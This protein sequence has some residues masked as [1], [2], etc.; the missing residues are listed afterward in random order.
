MTPFQQLILAA[1]KALGCKATRAAIAKRLK[2]P[3]G[4]V[5]SALLAMRQKKIISEEVWAITQGDGSAR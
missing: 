1:I 4:T 3:P 5:A 2:K